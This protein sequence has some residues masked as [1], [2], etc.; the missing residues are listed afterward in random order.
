MPVKIIQQK[1]NVSQTEAS[2][3][4]TSN[5]IVPALKV[6]AIKAPVLR[7]PNI[8]IRAI[9]IMLMDIKIRFSRKTRE[10]LEK[11]AEFSDFAYGRK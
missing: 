1:R 11:Y 5:I 7:T 8:I 2:G 10:D 3:T 6:P 9:R 4:S